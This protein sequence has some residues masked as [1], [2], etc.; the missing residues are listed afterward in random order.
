MWVLAVV[1]VVVIA[2]A[3]V[4]WRIDGIVFV[5][6]WVV[7]VLVVVLLEVAVVTPAIAMADHMSRRAAVEVRVVVVVVAMTA[8]TVVSMG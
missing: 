5:I 2:L 3:T 1:A 4:V 7:A 6:A 8:T